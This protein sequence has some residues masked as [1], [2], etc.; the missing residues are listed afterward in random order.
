MH[1][2]HNSRCLPWAAMLALA[3]APSAYA[4][5]DADVFNTLLKNLD[6]VYVGL[7]ALAYTSGF[8]LIGIAFSRMKKFGHITAFMHNNSGIVKPALLALIGIVLMYTPSMLSVFYETL[9]GYS[10][11][12]STT[13]WVASKASSDWRLALQ[14]VIG[15]VQ[16]FGLISFIRGWFLL[17]KITSEQPQPGMTSKGIVHVVA[18]V[19]A[20]NIT[21]TIDTIEATFGM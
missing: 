14:S 11:V 17:T 18:G 9:W 13:S 6:G 4:L 20:I 5:N 10:S 2:Q 3:Y 15:L 7:V 1:G 12:Q 16:V 8:I 21:G 19:L